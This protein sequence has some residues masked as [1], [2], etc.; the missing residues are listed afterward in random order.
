MNDEA[1]AEPGGAEFEIKELPVATRD[2]AA[3]VRVGG[4]GEGGK[5]W[6]LGSRFYRGN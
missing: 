5:V 4:L 3:T 2:E 6:G 1:K